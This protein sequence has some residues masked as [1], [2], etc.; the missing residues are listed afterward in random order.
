[1]SRVVKEQFFVIS[2]FIKIQAVIIDR[3]IDI[4]IIAVAH[5]PADIHNVLAALFFCFDGM[6]RIKYCGS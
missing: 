6:S 5:C 3:H 2:A 1:M 4:K